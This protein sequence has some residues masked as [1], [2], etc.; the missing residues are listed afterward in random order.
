MYETLRQDKG[1]S[2]VHTAQRGY[3]MSY[4]TGAAETAPPPQQRQKVPA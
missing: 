4:E 1:P 3:H 2:T